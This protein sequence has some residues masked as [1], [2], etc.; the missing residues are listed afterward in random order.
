MAWITA[1][2][3][4]ELLLLAVTV[5]LVSFNCSVNV[6]EELPEITNG[7]VV[8][9][10]VQ[11]TS[12]LEVVQAEELVA[13]LSEVTTLL[14][15]A[16][17]NEMAPTNEEE[18]TALPL[19]VIFIVFSIAEPAEFAEKVIVAKLST[20]DF[21]RFVVLPTATALGVTTVRSTVMLLPTAPPVIVEAMLELA[22]NAV[23]EI[24]E[25]VEVVLSTEPCELYDA[26]SPFK[27]RVT[28]LACG[29]MIGVPKWK[30]YV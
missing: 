17:S 24:T 6:Y 14:L 25:K 11:V 4:T 26:T 13:A 22:P 28:E 29:T 5:P 21:V 2:K 1:P 12:Q 30:V 20:P 7:V 3:L 18:L 15:F 27:V 8:V 10:K 16:S 9:E 19:K 23:V